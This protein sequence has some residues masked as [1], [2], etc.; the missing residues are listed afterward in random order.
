[1]KEDVNIA[2]ARAKQVVS[3]VQQTIATQRGIKVKDDI[4]PTVSVQ[5]LQTRNGKE[6]Q[7][8]YPAVIQVDQAESTDTASERQLVRGDELV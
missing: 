4:Q 6:V 7:T 2:S 1:M 8:R 5:V 3:P